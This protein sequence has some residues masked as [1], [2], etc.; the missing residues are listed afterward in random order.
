M[1]PDNYF[2]S[3]PEN[4]YL[5]GFCLF[6]NFCSSKILC[7]KNFAFSLNKR[8]PDWGLNGDAVPNAY[9]KQN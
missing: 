5:E 6:H 7:F 9:T 2:D 8:T 3:H 1:A 4:N